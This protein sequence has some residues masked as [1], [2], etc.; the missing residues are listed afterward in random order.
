MA[1]NIGILTSMSWNSNGWEDTATKEDIANSNYDFVKENKWMH[2]DI[3]FGFDKYKIEK[4]G[5]YIAYIPQF[6]KLPS[7]EESKYVSIVFIKSYNYHIDKN[8]IV[9][10]YAFPEIDFFDRYAD[11]DKYLRYDYGNLKTKPELS[12][13][14]I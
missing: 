14:H 1:K 5:N 6:N 2:E 8:L 10:F 12:L 7:L 11:D 9:G 3:N 4:D 13:I